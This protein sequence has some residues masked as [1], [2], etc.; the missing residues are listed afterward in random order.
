VEH[1]G[2]VYENEEAQNPLS[3]EALRVLDLMK[4][5]IRDG[6]SQYQSSTQSHA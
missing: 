4:A 6:F 5:I 3:K 2:G 1:P